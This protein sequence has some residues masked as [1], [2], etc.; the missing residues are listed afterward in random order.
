MIYIALLRGVNVGGKRKL[1][2]PELR[3][4]LAD[5]GFERVSTYINSGNIIF[6]SENPDARALEGRIV[7]LISDKFALEVPTLVISAAE[8]AAAL[9][10]APDWWGDDPEA[11]HNAIFVLPPA[12]AEDVCATVGEIKPEYERMAYH[13]Q[14]IYWSAPRAT[15]SHTRWS[16]VVGTS[17]YASVTIRNADT[18]RKLAALT[19]ED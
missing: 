13:G 10:H 18:A 11:K 1:P 7:R 4:A 3:A 9:T 5:A 16:K 15:F 14:V 2:M 19:R 17:A 12:T 8:L 6:T